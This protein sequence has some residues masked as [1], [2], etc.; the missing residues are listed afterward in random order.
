MLNLILCVDDDTIASMLCKMVITKTSFSNET[1]TAYNGE[2]ALNYFNTLKS[3]YSN[4]ESIKKPQLI[5]LDLNMPVMDGFTAARKMKD[6]FNTQR[7]DF[8]LSNI[9]TD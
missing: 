9:I 2:E 5:F 8:F 7:S 6:F 4:A 3:N 1:V